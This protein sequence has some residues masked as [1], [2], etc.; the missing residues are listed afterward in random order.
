MEPEQSSL[1][2][3][4]SNVLERFL[5]RFDVKGEISKRKHPKGL[6]PGLNTTKV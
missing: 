2:D 6:E 4:S 3:C 5:E 1:L